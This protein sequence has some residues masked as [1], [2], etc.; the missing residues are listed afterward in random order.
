[1][2]ALEKIKGGLFIHNSFSVEL[3]ARKFTAVN[4][5]RHCACVFD[6]SCYKLYSRLQT[7]FL[8]DLVYSAAHVLQFVCDGLNS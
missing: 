8:D 6:F 7:R 5:N 4:L 3:E 1:M 2:F